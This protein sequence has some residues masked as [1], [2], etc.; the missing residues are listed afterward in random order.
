M[1]GKRKTLEG[2]E[3]LSAEQSEE[4]TPPKGLRRLKISLAPLFR[5]NELADTELAP[6]RE[7]SRQE[8]EAI[9][10]VRDRTGGFL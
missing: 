4:D 2:A 5:L 1:I 3:G 7:Q 10:W 6:A 8:R 9:Q